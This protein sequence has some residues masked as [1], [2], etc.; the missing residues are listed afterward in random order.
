MPTPDRPKKKTPGDELDA[1]L[2]ASCFP[3]RLV[4]HQ[5]TLLSDAFT[6]TFRGMGS[7]CLFFVLGNNIISFS[8]SFFLRY[9][10]KDAV[11]A[12]A[13]T[14][15]VV[16]LMHPHYHMTIIWLHPLP[17]PS[18]CFSAANQI[19]ATHPSHEYDYLKRF[20]VQLRGFLLY[21]LTQGQFSV[22]WKRWTP[23]PANPN[24]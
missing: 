5:N 17:S 11:F 2:Q 4:G 13:N 19:T 1:S 7:L 6:E 16:I 3:H 9:H 20:T 10:T 24:Q 21:C 15:R 18:C 12:T 23:R 14:G 22:L 8:P